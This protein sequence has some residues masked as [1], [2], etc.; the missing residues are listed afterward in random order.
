[1]KRLRAPVLAVAVLA[2]CAASAP[3]S[4]GHRHGG[5]ERGDG[6]HDRGRP[7]ALDRIK[8]IVVVYEENHSFDNLYGGWEGV[9]GLASA[10]AAHTAQ[11]D[12]AG[13]PYKC[14]LQVDVNLASPPLGTA[15]SAG[16]PDNAFASQFPNRFF[17]IDDF[18]APTDTTCPAPG[19]VGAE[20]RAQ[21]PGRAGRLHARPRAPL[22]PGAV[23]AQR[24]RPEPLRDGLGRGRPDD[25][26]LRHEEAPDLRLPARP[27]PSGL[28]HRRPLLPGGVRRLVPQP[29]V[30]DRRG[31]ADVPAAPPPT[32]TRSSTTTGSRTRRTRCT[33]RPATCAT[34]R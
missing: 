12:Q 17:T 31:H 5:H 29:P 6:R 28:R 34:A 19:V 22:L 32:C 18:I 1:M 4:D 26:R 25:G 27:R 30:A 9:T 24:R 11:V 15:C 3:A 20:R 13:A 21:G 8:H 23:P 16:P 2:L 14:L 10:D 33:R 7:T